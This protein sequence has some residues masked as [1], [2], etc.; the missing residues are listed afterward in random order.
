MSGLMRTYNIIKERRIDYDRYFILAC[1]YGHFT[2]EEFYRDNLPG[3]RYYRRCTLA[4]IGVQRVWNKFWGVHKNVRYNS[5]THIQKI[6]RKYWCLKMWRPIV[7]LRM[8]MGKRTYYIL[9]FR[10]WLDYHLICRA[11]KKAIAQRRYKSVIGCILNVYI[12]FYLIV[13]YILC[14][15]DRM[16]TTLSAWYRWV[17]EE[18]ARKAETLRRF[19]I[20]I[21]YGQAQICFNAWR[22]YSTASKSLKQR[23]RRTMQNPH[24]GMWVRY[25]EWSKYI[26]SLHLAAQSIQR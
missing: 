2:K 24:F 5:A 18:K 9:F 21:K 16:I 7:R 26:R 23:V 14:R 12:C 6:W 19:I 11:I 3:F 1:R 17:K 10:L 22:E 13:L 4:A 20:R 8:K 15:L 25:V